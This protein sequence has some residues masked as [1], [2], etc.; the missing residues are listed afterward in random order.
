MTS[1]LMKSKI[2]VNENLF[3][4]V[5]NASQEVDKESCKEETSEEEYTK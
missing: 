4:S 2:Y 3:L 1:S 5:L